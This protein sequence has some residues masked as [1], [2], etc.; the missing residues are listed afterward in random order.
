MDRISFRG[1]EAYVVGYNYS[2]MN[3][4]LRIEAKIAN[5]GEIFSGDGRYSIDVC[6]GLDYSEP[7]DLDNSY[8][9]SYLSLNNTLL[10]LVPK[11]GFRAFINYVQ[12]GRFKMEVVNIYNN[13]LVGRF[14]APSTP[15]K[16][17]DYF[18]EN[19]FS[20]NFIVAYPAQVSPSKKF[21]EIDDGKSFTGSL[22]NIAVIGNKTSYVVV[23]Y[24][25]K[26][27]EIDVVINPKGFKTYMDNFAKLQRDD[28]DTYPIL[29][30][31][32]WTGANYSWAENTKYEVYD[33]KGDEIEF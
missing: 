10:A 22:H 2:T 19:Y 16:Y 32:M 11:Q 12:Q 18:G 3:G 14:I 29:T 33:R 17:H 28:K 4:S 25:K 9:E 5:P 15:A 30:Q 20:A 1:I 8:P 21:N 23:P 7:T 26:G 31:F 27:S 13:F 6:S 24:L